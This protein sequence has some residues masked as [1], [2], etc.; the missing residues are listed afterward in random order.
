VKSARLAE[1]NA[2]LNIDDRLPIE[3]Q[4]EEH[5]IAGSEKPS[6]LDKLKNPCVPGTRIKNK[7]YDV[8]LS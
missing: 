6:V 4:I 8:E 2:E 1:L 5:T 3:H 7:S